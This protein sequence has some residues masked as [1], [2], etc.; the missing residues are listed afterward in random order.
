RPDQ[1]LARLRDLLLRTRQLVVQP[2]GL[3]LLR[4][5][6]ALQ[7]GSRRL[8]LLQT[9][10]QV[11]GLAVLLPQLGLELSPVE[12]L[13][14]LA[15]LRLLGG[16]LLLGAVLALGGRLLDGLLGPGVLLLLCRLG[17]FRHDESALQ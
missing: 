8:Q 5:L 16:V 4:V 1:L 17:L 7:L 9:L 12:R 2:L 13:L 15:G 14:L 6:D 3:R 10:P 11:R